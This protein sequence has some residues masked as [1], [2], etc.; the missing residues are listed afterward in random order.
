MKNS[1]Y[2]LRLLLV[3]LVLCVPP[4]G[5]TQLGSYYL[6]KE[7]GVLLGFCVG[8]PCV[9]WACWK[10]FIDGWR[11]EDEEQRRRDW[12]VSYKFLPGLGFYGFGLYH[13]IGGLGKLDNQSFMFIGQQK[14]NNIKSRQYR[15]FGMANP[16]GYRKAL[17]LMKLAEKF[18]IP[19]VALIDTP[20][21]YPGI[22][23]EEKGQAEAIAR[24][25]YEMFK[26]RTQIIVVVI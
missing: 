8:I 18:S 15:N 11:E 24:N 20:G 6:G 1:K 23:A 9:T 2:F 21:A 12:F 4:I 22:E 17:R 14:G 25:L 19:I 10:L 16:E 26:I 7:N 3:A 13:M 5:A